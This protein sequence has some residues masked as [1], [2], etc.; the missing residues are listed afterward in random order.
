MTNLFYYIQNV[1][2]TQ[3]EGKTIFLNKYE[4]KELMHLIF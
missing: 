4:R 1:G 3:Q 2:K